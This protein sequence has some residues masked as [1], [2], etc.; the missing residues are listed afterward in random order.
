M[1]TDNKDEPQAATLPL[2]IA[3]QWSHAALLKRAEALS[4]LAAQGDGQA[5]ETLNGYSGHKAMLSFRA[6][7]GVVEFHRDFADLFCVLDGAATLVT[8]GEIV[9]PKIV[10]PGEIRGASIA[11]G[12]R[13]LLEAGSIAHVPAAVPHQ[14]LIK[15]GET[16]TA[17][18]LKI[19]QAS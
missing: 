17:F 4:E 8:G 14:L 18:V 12:K 19:E 3:D 11:G 15:P 9:E 2:G 6:C 16:F 5:S 13:Q 1:T 7:D 10:A